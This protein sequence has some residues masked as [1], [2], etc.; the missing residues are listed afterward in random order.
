MALS[1][2]ADARPA[3]R[4]ATARGLAGRPAVPG[5]E[6][7]RGA[8]GDDDLDLADHRPEG[9]GGPIHLINTCLN[10]TRDGAS[11]LY[12]AGP[13]GTLVALSA[14]GRDRPRDASSRGA[15]GVGTLGRWVAVSARR[16]APAPACDTPDRMVAA[17]ISSGAP[18]LLDARGQRPEHVIGG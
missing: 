5:A 6:N 16:L 7:A 14:R 11:G 12:N 1:R 10:Q 13:Q 4:S 3:S 9:P 17:A 18:G 2:P 15:G 8:Q